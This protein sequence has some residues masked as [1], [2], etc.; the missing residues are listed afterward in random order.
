MNDKKAPEGTSAQIREGE[1]GTKL[2][3]VHDFLKFKRIA[4]VGVSRDEKEFS[5]RLF[6]DLRGQGYDVIPV[7]PAALQLDGV[8][9][10][11]AV[12]QISPAPEGVLLMVSPA[13]TMEMLQTCAEAG[14]HYVW[15][16][17][18]SGPGPHLQEAVSFS[19]EHG[20]NLIAGYCPYMF[21]PKTG[22]FHR[23]HGA[24]NR[25]TGRYP[26]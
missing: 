11:A 10:E 4:M 8:K 1:I 9:C 25:V 13:R 16:Y 24:I 21:L 17:G 18:M 20:M 12:R 19:R 7:N 22:F 5:R 14:V 26:R 23:F 6:R 3:D 15:I 2:E